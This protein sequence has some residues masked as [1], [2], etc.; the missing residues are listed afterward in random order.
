MDRGA[1]DGVRGLGAPLRGQ[2]A[3]RQAMGRKEAFDQISGVVSAV[4]ERSA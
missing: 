3:D 1:A 2:V 4:R